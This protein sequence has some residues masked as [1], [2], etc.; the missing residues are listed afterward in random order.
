MSNLVL[1][2]E[3]LESEKKIKKAFEIIQKSGEKEIL[4]RAKRILLVLN[5]KNMGATT[6]ISAILYPLVEKQKISLEE[7]N[8]TFGQEV[9]LIAKECVRI[10]EILNAN[11]KKIP[12]E[13]LSALILSI[14]TDL[15]TIII[16]IADITDQL[17]NN[18]SIDKNKFIF[19]AKNIYSP[20]T[21]KLGISDLGWQIA[22]Y[23]F[24]LENPQGYEKIKKLVNK[25]REEREKLIE[26][27]RIEIEKFLSGK[28]K[29]HVFG[30]PKN[31][32]SIHEKLKK[33]SFKEMHDIYGIRII[34]NKERECYEILGNIHSKYN[35][36]P[37]AF[38]DYIAKEGKGLGKKGYQSIHTAI[39]R[40]NDVIEIQIRTWQ[41]HLKTESS[42]YWEYKRLRK[43]TTLDKSLSWERQLVEWQKSIGEENKNKKIISGKLF[44]FTPK[45]EVITLPNNSSALDFAFAVHSDIGKRV[46]QA[47]INGE[48]VPIETK[49]KNLDKV[50]IITDQKTKIRPDWLNMVV[51]ERAKTKIKRHF[52]LKS[53]IVKKQHASEQITKKIKLAECCH[54]LP[55]EDVIGIKTTKRK[56]IIHKRDCK[57][58]AN[59]SKNKKIEIYFEKE[60][61]KTK[62]KVLAIDRIG[63]LAE[64]LEEIKRNKATL[65]STNFNIKKSGYVEAIFELEIKNINALERLINNLEQIPSIQSVDRE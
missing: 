65:S 56:I 47:K 13:T 9:M 42:I 39:I 62:I 61:G 54:P 37:S 3:T 52:G 10:E 23:C 50:E 21:A 15:R 46:K 57:N 11:Y 19:F 36:I 40:N 20:L 17:K 59:I 1:N 58:I 4:L 30:R 35:F 34:C 12:P 8:N 51:S 45:N 24:K 32:Y 49:L 5:K 43:D 33:V 2:D 63:L 29:V 64:I 28:I 38:D 25:T 7:I 48:L 55:G 16:K 27:I 60:R 22:D 18:S 6:T 14:S 31:F 41:Q 53:A 44:V 26:D